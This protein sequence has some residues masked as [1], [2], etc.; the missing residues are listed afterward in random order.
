MELEF[1]TYRIMDMSDDLLEKCAALYS[2][3]YGRYASY[4]KKYNENYK[5]GANIKMSKSFMKKLYGSTSEVMFV[6]AFVGSELVGQ[7]IYLRKHYS[8]IGT[9]TWVLQLVVKK[10]YRRQKIGQ[11]LLHSIWGFSNDVAWGLATANPYTVQTLEAVTFRKVEPS[12][13]KKHIKQVEAIL[14]DVSFAKKAVIDINDEHSF[15][16]TEFPVDHSDNKVSDMWRLGELPPAQEWLAFT[17]KSQDIDSDLFRDNYPELINFSEERLKD[18]YS[19]MKMREQF[20]TSGTVEEVN[21]IQEVCKLKYTK[22]SRILDIGCGIG[23]HSIEFA[24]RGYCVTGLDYSERLLRQADK[25]AESEHLSVC[26]R[27]LDC[28]DKRNFKRQNLYECYDVVIC[29]YDVIGSFPEPEDNIQIIK[30]AY[31]ALKPNGYLVLSVMNYELT[32]NCAKHTVENL[33]NKPK[34]L[35]NLKA[36]NTMQKTGDVF[37]PEFYLV[38]KSTHTVFRKEEFVEDGGIPAEYVIRDVRYGMDEIISIMQE[39]K[40]EVID[41]RY[42]SA[43]KWKNPYEKGTD[44]HAKEI[45]LVCQKQCSNSKIASFLRHT[46]Y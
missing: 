4:A 35:L 6:G 45:L 41:A 39:E 14:A 9:M 15:I 5:P 18:A 32:K 29:L 31:R 24:K 44:L 42:V 19:R 1:Q 37:N 17:F 33:S 2:E 22:R 38:E 23:R 3:N 20:W 28:R 36:S 10:E 25:K 34:S 26:F 7:A 13:I 40:F 43:G 8:R 27:E 12:I 46:F 30:N 16:N 21:Y 11:R